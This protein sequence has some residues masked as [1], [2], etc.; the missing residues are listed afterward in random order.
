MSILTNIYKKVLT[1][2]NTYLADPKQVKLLAA[3]IKLF[4]KIPDS[5][6]RKIF[7]RA[8]AFDVVENNRV[9]LII[10][11]SY[12]QYALENKKNTNLDD[13]LV[14]LNKAA[15]CF[16]R[17][18]DTNE[19]LPPALLSEEHSEQLLIAN[20]QLQK[21]KLLKA[22]MRLFFIEKEIKSNSQDTTS[23]RKEL[24]S[25]I[26]EYNNFKKILN[27]SYKDPILREQLSI[28]NDLL[29]YI[30]KGFKLAKKLFD[31]TAAQQTTKRYHT[32]TAPVVDFDEDEEMEALSKTKKK[33]QD[34]SNNQTSASNSTNTNSENGTTPFE[35]S[36]L[37]ILSTAALDI[38]PMVITHN[39]NVM[40]LHMPEPMA[41]TYDD[42]IMALPMSEPN[43][44]V[45]TF[46][47]QPHLSQ[48]A[49]DSKKFLNEFNK[50][51]HAYF[52]T[53]DEYSEAQRTEKSLEKIA[54]SLLFAA[55]NLKKESSVFKD[56][57]FNPAIQMA[58][59]LFSLA[60]AKETQTAYEAN[61]KLNGLSKTYAP[62][63]KP[64]VRS[65]L[66]TPPEKFISHLRLQFS[67][68]SQANISFLGLELQ[69]IIEKLLKH[70]E[71]VLT[72]D[73]YAKVTKC[74]LDC[75]IQAHDRLMEHHS[76]FQFS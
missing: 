32:N 13:L 63:L 6:L 43:L 48:S 67:T 3:N 51:A 28:D 34:T 70:L 2:F 12:I 55:I 24:R 31:T 35:L 76:Q 39:D 14:L 40:V 22:D 56:K 4:E 54:H 44:G 52:Y 62:L 38:A 42:N 61:E 47:T 37:E 21:I 36:G 73:D 69:E 65:L 9:L 1:N 68:E 16:Q 10:A 29:N 60:C 49:E 18:I 75:L 46:G 45:Q 27:K 11:D 72:S 26:H 41:L 7:K 25:I 19:S 15:D 66:R 8:S 50:W 58:L 17:T 30:D 5:D 23:I 59:Q 64:F 53:R 20:F 33:K 71:T 57:R 74:C